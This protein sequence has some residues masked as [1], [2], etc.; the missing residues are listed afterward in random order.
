MGILFTAG[1]TALLVQEQVKKKKVAL[2][3]PICLISIII[4]KP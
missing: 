2:A 3:V 4:Q 1:S